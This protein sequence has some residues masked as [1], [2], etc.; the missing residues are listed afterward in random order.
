MVRWSVG[1]LRTG[2]RTLKDREHLMEENIE[3]RTRQSNN[4]VFIAFA[5]HWKRFACIVLEDGGKRALR[6]GFYKNDSVE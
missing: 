1:S 2:H 5:Y 6:P 3:H 4:P